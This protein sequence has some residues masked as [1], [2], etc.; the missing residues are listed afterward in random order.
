M[1]LPVTPDRGPFSSIMVESESC[2]IS[3]V[4]AEILFCNFGPKLTI[5]TYLIG[6]KSMKCMFKGAFHARRLSY[7]SL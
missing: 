3:C 1:G 4:E 7:L 5:R 2:N 6:V